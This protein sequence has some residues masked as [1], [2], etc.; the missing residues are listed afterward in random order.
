M[1]LKNWKIW[2]VIFPEG[3]Y[4][5]IAPKSGL[6][7]K[8]S[9]TVG[10]GVVDRDYQGTLKVLLCNSSTSDF[11]FEKETAI[12]QLI[13]EKILIPA[14]QELPEETELPKTSRGIGG[15]GSTDKNW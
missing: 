14:C 1:N 13:C 8:K 3:T 7:V 15:F 5:R 12:A 4:G 2:T 6:S 10:A 11:I 9:I